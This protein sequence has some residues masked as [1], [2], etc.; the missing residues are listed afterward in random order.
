MH[1]ELAEFEMKYWLKTFG[2]L[3]DWGIRCFSFLR[4]S[5]EFIIISELISA[6]QSQRGFCL[7][8]FKL[9][10]VFTQEIHNISNRKIL[11]KLSPDMFRRCAI[12]QLILALQSQRSLSNWLTLSVKNTIYIYSKN[13]QHFQYK[14][15]TKAFPEIR[16]KY[17]KQKYTT[18]NTKQNGIITLIGAINSNRNICGAFRNALA[19]S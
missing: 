19:R 16:Y 18:E 10:C 2:Y 17:S 12:F 9:L 3:V 13:P 11:R 5:L 7:S 8:M 4:I 14:S 6:L 15:I 1:A